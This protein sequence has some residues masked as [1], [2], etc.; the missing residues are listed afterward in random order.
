M[1]I[2]NRKIKRRLS[3]GDPN[4]VVTNEMVEEANIKSMADRISALM[5]RPNLSKPNSSTANIT[6]S[7]REIPFKPLRIAP[8]LNET[9]T[10][11]PSLSD[12]LRMFASYV[13]VRNCF[14]LFLIFLRK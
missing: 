3:R 8:W 2:E 4:A 6:Q 7:W 14:I 1:A 9:V 13:S 10:Q 5:P 12:E 11:Q